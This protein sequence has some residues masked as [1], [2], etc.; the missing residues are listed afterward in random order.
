MHITYNSYNYIVHTSHVGM[1][2]IIIINLV[3]TNPPRRIT[4]RPESEIFNLDY[5]NNILVYNGLETPLFQRV[6][7]RPPPP[8]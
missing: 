4:N 2:L 3:G 5:Y 7:N 8:V 1:L 6:P